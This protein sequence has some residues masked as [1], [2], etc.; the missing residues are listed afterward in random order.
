MNNQLWQFA[1][2]TVKEGAALVT[3][4]VLVAAIT[5][6]QYV[7][8]H[9]IKASVAIVVACLFFFAAFFRAWNKVYKELQEEL[10]K[11]G[12][13][14]LTAQFEVV[15]APPRTMVI[16]NNSSPSPAVGVSIQEIRNGD[17]VL[18]FSSPNPVRYGVPGTWVECWILENGIQ[19][20]NDVLALFSGTKFI[21]QMSTRF[22]LRIT[23]SSLDSRSAQR[24]WVL[25]VPFW[26]DTLHGKICMGQQNVEPL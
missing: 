19:R 20:R 22:D 25:A 17:K 11:H 8:G 3:G 2:S 7:T 14:D 6:W 18:Q 1:V 13:P 23:F 10:F 12:R 21:G 5:I 26:Y 16:L 9:N 4:G 15:D 24:S